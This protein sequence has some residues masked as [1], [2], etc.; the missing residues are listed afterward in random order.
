MLTTSPSLL[1]RLQGTDDHGAWER[2]VRLYS[3]IL[4]NAASRLGLQHADALDLVQEVFATLVRK[5][6]EFQYDT[7]RSFRSWLF[8]VTRNTYIGKA[9]RKKVHIDLSVRPDNLGN[10]VEQEAVDRAD[11]HRHLLTEVFPAMSQY[12]Q[13]STWNA[14]YAYVVEQQPIQQVAAKLG[15]TESAVLKAKARVLSRLHRELPDLAAD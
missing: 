2:F 6:P 15:G 8:T 4:Y 11:F 12:F 1:G 10:P 3:P 9:R 5:L 13:P 7:D 14:F